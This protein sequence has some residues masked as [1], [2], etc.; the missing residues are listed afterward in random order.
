MANRTCITCGVK[1]VDKDKTPL[2][3]KKEGLYSR[4]CTVSELN[5]L[6]DENDLPENI[7]VKIRYNS[8]VVEGSIN[9]EKNEI[10]FSSPQL[11]V[12]PGQSIVFYD[13]EVCLGGAIING[14][15]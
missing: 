8:P 14:R 15:S 9:L 10:S 13:G 5:W 1:K 11:S 2:W 4:G 7:Q 3:S 6:V 12:T